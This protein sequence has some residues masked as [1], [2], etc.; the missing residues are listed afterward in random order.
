MFGGLVTE[1]DDKDVKAST[2]NETYVV[3]VTEKD[4]TFTK[5]EP[6]GDIPL[7]R[8][9]HTVC[10][11]SP[12]KL[13]IFGGYYDNKTRLNDVCFLHVTAS[14][15][16][17]KRPPN[18]PAIEDPPKNEPSPIGAPEPRA[19]A[20]ACLLGNK[21]Y[22]FGGY[23]GIHY[24]RKNFSDLY[25]YDLEK[26]EWAKIEYENVAPD[27]RSGHIIFPYGANSIYLLGGW[28]NELQFKS[29]IKFDLESRN[30]GN[31]EL[32]LDE[33]IWN[34]SGLLVNAIPNKKYFLFGGMTGDFEEGKDRR[35]GSYT[36]KSVFIDLDPKSGFTW[37]HI[38]LDDPGSKPEKPL[39]R[40]R[41][42]MFY[43]D[44]YYR[45]VI[46]GGWSN[47]WLG[48]AYALNVGKIVGPDYAIT[49]MDPDK[50]QL[51][52]GTHV[53]IKGIGFTET[54]SM[55]V[56]FSSGKQFAEAPATYVS[57]DELSCITPSFEAFGPKDVE[58]KIQRVNEDLSIT[59]C[60]F[61]F[62][63][64]TRAIK[65]LA[66]GP[67]ISEKCMVGN[68]AEFIIQARNEDGENRTSG[69]DTFDAKAFYVEKK[70]VKT[71]VIG[72]EFPRI[73]IVEEIVEEIPC[74]I[75]DK[76]DGSYLV[77]YTAK[78][79]GRVKIE[80]KF[81]NEKGV[82]E[83]IRGSPFYT[84]FT[85]EGLTPAHNK[86]DGPMIMENIH[87]TLEELDQFMK[88]S[89]TGA[90]TKDKDI[91]GNVKIL[92]K[93]KECVR[94]VESRKDELSLKLDV[95]EEALKLFAKQ[96]RHKESDSRKLRELTKQWNEVQK[97]ARDTKKEIK[98]VVEQEQD[99]TGQNVKA[100]EEKLK[101]YAT[102]IKKKEFYSYSS[103]VEVALKK[104]DA[105]MED[106]KGFMATFQDKEEDAI[107][108]GVP[109][110]ME[111][112][113]K[114]LRD[115]KNDIETMIMLW[116]HIKKCLL[117]FEKFKTTPLLKGDIGD[118]IEET[119]KL[120]VALE[121]IKVDRKNNDAYSGI[122]KLIY[123][124]TKFLGLA[125]MLRDPS[126]K[127]RHWKRLSD[128]VG[129]PVIGDDKLLLSDIF[130]LDLDNP[131]MSDKVDDI[132]LEAKQ[133]LMIEK[134]LSDVK[135]RWN[136]VTFLITAYKEGVNEVNMKEEELDKVDEDQT[137]IQSMVSNKYVKIFEQEVENWRSG[138]FNL[139]ENF[140]GLRDVYKSWMFLERL[141]IGSEELKKELPQKAEEFV[142]YDKEVRDLLKKAEET[143]FV[144]AFCN[145][146]GLNKKLDKIMK[147]LQDSEKALT[148]FMDQKRK[149]FPRFY[150]VARDDLLTI[151][152]RGDNPARVMEFFPK[153]F[154]GIKDIKMKEQPGDRPLAL[155]MNS[156]EDGVAETVKF[157]EDMKLAGKV[158]K[159]LSDL[160]DL[161][162]RTLR[163]MAKKS[164]VAHDTKDRS[165]WLKDDA[166][167]ITHLVNLSVWVRN[168]EKAI[169]DIPNDKESMKK[170]Y[171]YQVSILNK[172]ISVVKGKMA[173]ELRQKVKIM[174]IMDTH[175]RDIIEKL[176]AVGVNKVDDFQWQCQL[177]T[178]WANE[179]FRLNIGDAEFWY[180]YEYIGNGGR[181]V[182]TPLT[183]RIYVTATQ[184]L[185]LKMG[186]APAGPAGTGKT[187]TTKDLACAMG[188]PVYVF[189][190]S[191]AMNNVVMA[192]CFKGIASSGAWGCFDEFN[193]LI[194][195]TLSVCSLQFGSICD[196]LKK[197]QQRFLFS[198][199]EEIDLDKTG[200]VFITMNPGYLG[201]AELPEGLKTLFRP[202]TVVVPDFELIAE[203]LLMAEGFIKAKVLARKF[204]ILYSLCQDLLS[205]QAHYDWT[206]RSIKSVLAVA[207]GFKRD[208]PDLDELALLKR[209]LRDFNM[210]KILVNDIPVIMGLLEDL[211]P[212][213]VVE[214]KRDLKFEEVIVDV[215]KKAKLFPEP[216]FIE[217][218]VQ[219]KELLAIRHCI[220]LMGPAGSGKST[221]W[222]TLIN[223]YI[224]D[225]KPSLYQDLNP[226]TV[227]TLDLY[228]YINP[229]GEWR[230]GLLSY[231]MKYFSEEIKDDRTK[232]I[233]LDGDLDTKWIES[234]NSVMDDS[235]MLTLA[236]NDR[237]VLKLY[238]RLLFEI[239]DLR[240]ASPA[241][242]SRAGIIYISDNDGYQYEAYF[243]SW[244][245]KQEYSADKQKELET[246][247]ANHVKKILFELKKSYKFVVPVVDVSM[248]TC[249]CKLLQALVP[250][251]D[252]ESKSLQNVFAYCC[253]WAF[254]GGLLDE[255]QRV[256]FSNYFKNLGA[257]RYASGHVYDYFPSQ[258]SMKWEKWADSVK[259]LTNYTP[260]VAITEVTVPTQET[261]RAISL[262]KNLVQVDYYPM[263]IG[264]AG[265][266]KTQI[267]K[268]MLKEINMEKY[269]SMTINF[270]YFT[271]AKNLQEML[272]KPLKR[273]GKVFAPPLN[274]R[275]IYYLDDLN[276][277][278]RDEYDTQT[279]IELLRQNADYSHWFDRVKLKPKNIENTQYL[280]SM[281]PSAG[282]FAV[283]ARFQRHFWLLAVPMPEQDSL[284]RIYSTF[285]TAHFKK[286]KQAVYEQV[287]PILKAALAIHGAVCAKYKK[288][289]INFHYEF[290][291]RHISN[292]FQGIL[293]AQ[294]AQF[295]EPE[296]LIKLWMHE[297]ERIY[298]DRLVTKADIADY[299]TMMADK[300]KNHFTKFSNLY[301]CTLP[302][303]SE[304][305]V[306][307]MFA[308]GL[309]DKIYDSIPTLAALSELLND[310]LREYNDVNA[311]MNLVLFE[312]AM[313]HVCKIN[314][315]ISNPGGHILNI[316][317]GG[318]GK[319]SLSK[320]SMFICGY[321]PKELMIS[322]SYDM[323][324]LRL[325]IQSAFQ[326][327][328]CKEEGTLFFF[329]EGVLRKDDFLRYINDI[330]SSG[331][332]ADLYS[333][334]E[335]EALISSMRAAAKSEGIPEN[336]PDL[337]YDFFIQRVKKNL[338]LALC[339]SPGNK[340][341]ERASKFPA[342]V[343]CT[344]IDWFQPWPEEALRK[345]TA[346]N[347]APIE[348]PSEEVR[349]AVVDFMPESFNKVNQTCAEVLYI[350]RRYIYNTPKSF[351]ELIKLFKNMLDR[352]KQELENARARYTEGVER[353]KETETLAVQLAEELKTT[354]VVVEEKRKTA[355]ENAVRVE[356]TK[357]IVEESS[358]KAAIEAKLCAE[359]K[360]MVEEKQTKVQK[361]VDDAKPLVARA[362][363][364]VANLD[365]KLFQTIKGWRTAPPKRANSI[366]MCIIHLLYD[367]HSGLIETEK[368]GPKLTW[369]TFLSL[370]EIPAKLKEYLLKMIEK[371]D[372][373]KVPAKN[374]K[375]CNNIIANDAL[376]PENI[377]STSAVLVDLFDWIKNMLEYYDVVVNMEPK[378]RALAEANEQLKEATDKKNAIDAQV[379]K[380]QEELDVLQ[381]EFKKVMDA[382]ME[383]EATAAK[384]ARRLDVA[385]RLL[386]ALGSESERWATSIDTCTNQLGL[387]LGDV[388]LAS[389][390]VSYLGPFNKKY[391]E[392][393]MNEYFKPFVES[394]GIPKTPNFKHLDILTDDATRALW[395]NQGLPDD[396]F[397]KENGAILEN[398][399]RWAL[400]IDPQIQGNKWIRKKEE[401]HGLQIVRLSA[402]KEPREAKKLMQKL[403]VAIE[404]GT[405]VM[406]E[407]MEEEVNAV[408]MPIIGKMYIVKGKNKLLQLGD[409]QLNYNDN[410]RMILQTKLSNPHFPPEIQAETTM[411]NFAVTEEG[412][413]DQLLAHV[414]R[415]ERPDLA[416][417]REQLVQ[418]QNEFTIKLKE[419]EK[420]LL[421]K[422]TTTTG[423][424]FE[425]IE[426]VESLEKS[427]VLSEDISKKSAAAKEMSIQ[428]DQTSEMYRPAAARGALIFFVMTELSRVHSFYMFSLAAF[429]NVV[430]RSLAKVKTELL[431]A[432]GGAAPPA[433]G[434]DEE[435]KAPP[436]A[437]AKK[438]EKTGE[439]KTEAK[440]EGKEGE[441]TE[442]NK[443]ELTPEEVTKH[444]ANITEE[445]TY[446]SFIYI[447][448]GLFEKDRLLVAVRLCFRIQEKTN[449]I[450]MSKLSYLILGRQSTDLPHQPET[451]KQF[452]NDSMFRACKAL[453]E[454]NG[455][456][457]LLS[458]MEA[459]AVHWKKWYMEEKAEVNDLPKKFK[460]IDLFDRMLLLRALRPDRVTNALEMYI[461]QNMGTKYQD[462]PPFNLEATFPETSA[463]IPIFFVL[464]P[465]QDPTKD[466]RVV[467]KKE[468]LKDEE[469]FNIPMGQGQEDNA[470]RKL[471]AAAASGTWIML[472]NI[473]LM[474]SWLKTLE[475]NLEEVTGNPNTHPRFRCFLSSEPP[476]LPDMKLIPE[477][478]LQACIKVANEAPQD[479]KNNMRRAYNMFKEDR[480]NKCNK[481]L[482]F[483][484]L[485]FALCMYHSLLLGR[486]KYGPL[487]WCKRYNFNEGDL[488]ICADVL[489]NYLNKYEKVPY[490]DLRYI[491]GEIMYGGHITDGWDRRT[492]NAYLKELI[493]PE[494]LQGANLIQGYK[495]PDP[496]KTDRE[497]Y[498]KYIEK[499]PPESPEL[500]KMD[501]NA[502]INLL[503]MKTEN[504]FKDIITVQGGAAM[505]GASK[506]REDLV[507]EKIK[508]VKE[509]IPKTMFVMIELFAKAKEK[510]P[511][512]IVCLQECERMNALLEKIKTTIDALDLGYQGQLNINDDMERLADA[513]LLERVPP[514]WKEVISSSSKKPLGS[515]LGNITRRH[516]QL[517]KWSE[518]FTLEKECL[519]ISLLFNP[520]S[521]LTAIMQMTSRQEKRALDYMTLNTKV[522]NY[523]TVEEIPGPPES[524]A[525]IYGLYLQ[526][527]SWKVPSDRKMEGYLDQMRPRELT[528]T[529]PVVNVVAVPLEQ[530]QKA[531]YYECPVY[532]TTDRGF[533]YVFTATLRMESLEFNVNNWI[534]AG[535]ALV[536][537]N[538]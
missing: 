156:N 230:M 352:K 351:L 397:S 464:F 244:I 208:E 15:Y 425:N 261:V 536:M 80:V 252:K 321:S 334:D 211:F 199:E 215:V 66:Y 161:M 295:T 355:E 280:A 69:R 413:E 495:S 459:E 187:E 245:A 102:D 507:R 19:D 414:V 179:D 317:V 287:Q 180:W 58:V 135:N 85:E 204:I 28:S 454:I 48:D 301:K 53:R 437:E 435:G 453:E 7:K 283:S 60:K 374:I 201:R 387:L 40:A 372:E 520:M 21:V 436:P 231:W 478:I 297:S 243:K 296:K 151:L 182:I 505:S 531:G 521:F 185:H 237:I 384:C 429:I 460:Q 218:V 176:Q 255:D 45:I 171:D 515:W 534:L 26:Y 320:L 477:T 415:K 225:G 4:I 87:K 254:G 444:V 94:V 196:A 257:A 100:F 133:Q 441:K 470:I 401:A 523:M 312:D 168:V 43:D 391:R 2:T 476:P 517:A 442:E 188:K 23:G 134:K 5:I 192:T 522:K 12:D 393:I 209:A 169:N 184:A 292:V 412:L 361:D 535:V 152:A 203:I 175:S 235:K 409:K 84:V 490:D 456:Q 293:Q 104:L 131:K 492:N 513:I 407:N 103:G 423:D 532:T 408:V 232:W 70:E 18:H 240:F 258:E 147:N 121:A 468:G 138:L 223:S 150:F 22:I 427:K 59:G 503:T 249:L 272:E 20:A 140:L 163:N 497:G 167:Q 379:A 392:K 236:S 29:A 278:A 127:E 32:D 170:C 266:G 105:A 73:D 46:F 527:A 65:S 250:E 153:I 61:S 25:S 438:E 107:M 118:M 323:N 154:R 213:I 386:K 13:F 290:S 357:K 81:K 318:S 165:E 403:E 17:W 263:L 41:T 339:F 101:V 273:Q 220:F 342:I 388:L 88:E 112:S 367:P 239:R 494:L 144:Y 430:N 428:I 137:T 124:W 450:D 469:V 210:A 353:L 479:L 399:E 356:A 264:Y 405:S 277:P 424:I 259:E 193:R 228:G 426:L 86:L 16:T 376:T 396:P 432:K 68:E 410:F 90:A 383:A 148:L 331:D 262:M 458:Q 498:V 214:R 411:I 89:I 166:A 95:V 482:E 202:I 439:A 114:Q 472:Q 78:K 333:S 457:S 109:Q 316:G 178:Y 76:D 10:P 349:Q 284:N 75:V 205:K 72:E 375:E 431:A 142:A 309:R 452:M 434:K 267:C 528:P 363:A 485:L 338:H 487:G 398:S 56:R 234:M 358:A 395:I 49:S 44:R 461:Q 310:A 346:E 443:L 206:L 55:L 183:D 304:F 377:K 417:T 155:E 31:P 369:P 191:D 200:G 348:M 132:T 385:T 433:E 319:L 324:D 54:G 533:T 37:H 158:E 480:L 57:P 146:E 27:P 174:I 512:V 197:G 122:S 524:G 302:E 537:E 404:S 260:G 63:K 314:R 92:L 499:L 529:L 248:V 380:L 496:S 164:V 335:K 242:V 282:S 365:A 511:Y 190:C 181:L 1:N 279:A 64:N 162:R 141:F 307:S 130:A 306:F 111:I 491:F 281:N 216:R 35:V 519:C 275:L 186:C 382:K 123:K 30:W 326:K 189:N 14:E 52:G 359:K 50:G 483:K 347:L 115:L 195:E 418:Q 274:K 390:F 110:M 538:D 265:S 33:S 518:N 389:S 360:V 525:Y 139:S 227:S 378:R 233:V 500:F 509:G 276:M 354:S 125:D 288:T 463:K 446:Q 224:A 97:I 328:G 268:G 340:L 247:F 345:V 394:R 221:C 475:S 51:S 34:F 91:K 173:R 488:N 370:M 381:A 299:K 440:E 145:T 466:V 82:M 256:I 298:C 467:A 465:G 24:Q 83:I 493:K 96:N 530:K 489:N 198:G 116:N 344:V 445:L 400:M 308:T 271:D 226:K 270:N 126:M 330:L 157:I 366:G 246:C 194:P 402:L 486:R 343:N 303:N 325:D 71:E 516:A 473:H 501:A 6:K 241:T 504:L 117:Q 222:K 67:G 371:I 421:Y 160:I 329:T 291:V 447:R 3:Q 172:L 336:Q 300:V 484:A 113:K 119:K 311:K 207:G 481:P 373:G 212:G 420:L 350:D 238:M 108:F 177:K 341:R 506:R 62:F 136:S 313:R 305:L 38:E 289:A 337:I 362:Q 368:G 422:L 229:A 514:I 315:V 47:K 502:D 510:N 128:E 120:K 451:L 8:A 253:V 332:I 419:L 322:G 251:K 106:Y 42:A 406:V 416:N 93:I 285:L 77:K 471:Q 217:K 508:I 474:Q 269:T 364:N 159:Y 11:I 9:C 526:G 143:K 39:E 219:L 99:R 462:V 448:R 98:S 129:K 286:F 455:F 79:A 294:P 36:N 449:S 74:E 149:A 327:T